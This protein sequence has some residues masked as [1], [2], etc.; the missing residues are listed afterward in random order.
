MSTKTNTFKY[1]N[2]LPSSPTI[3]G[4]IATREDHVHLSFGFPNSDLFPIE[5]LRSAA[6]KAISNEGRK[7]LHYAGGPGIQKVSQ[8]IT[9]HVQK[10]DVQATEKDVLVTAGAG[11]AI[12]VISRTLLNPG[13]EVWVEA[14]TFFTALRSF[15]LVGATTR[16]FPIDSDGLQVDVLEKALREVHS[17]NQ[18]LP[19][20][21]YIMPNFHNPAGVVLSVERRQK[22]AQLAL[23]YNFYILEDDA[24]ADLNFVQTTLPSI[25]S[26]A[27]ERVAYVGTF[28]KIIG[29]GVRL[30]WV[31]GNDELLRN[32]RIFML[33]SQTNPFTQEILAHL[34]DELNF[35]DYLANLITT[36]RQ[37]R[38]VMI[39]ANR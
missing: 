18:K 28:S 7:A 2:T 32:L 27:P 23:E 8:W 9:R 33:G 30:G 21:V 11:Q 12:D 36:Y 20:L 4:T 19:K 5:E 22:L 6:D 34:L 24:Y 37:Q 25:Y 17:L 35:D 3:G 16:S 1:A 13:D 38:D 14:P 29:P 39:K 10:R 26:F 31:I 15:E